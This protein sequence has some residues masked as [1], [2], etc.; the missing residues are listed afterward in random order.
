MVAETQGVVEEISLNDF[1]SRVH[2]DDIARV[3]V[4]LD[5]AQNGKGTYEV[6]FRIR[7]NGGE[8]VERYS[9]GQCV[10]VEGSHKR[11]IGITIPAPN[12]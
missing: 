2:P 4:A 6:R 9:R 1:L 10:T 8:Y 3:K 5:G 7:P 11:L 12:D